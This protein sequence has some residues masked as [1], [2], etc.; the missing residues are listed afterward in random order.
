M[1]IKGLK[2]AFATIGAKQR[3]QYS[4]IAR[5]KNSFVFTAEVDHINKERNIYDHKQGVFHKKVRALSVSDGEAALTV[6]H[7]KELHFA[8]N[9]AFETNL[10]CRLLLV[11]GTKYGTSTGGVKGAVDGDYWIVKQVSGT[12]DEG[13][14]FILERV[15]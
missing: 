8:V 3:D 1:Y 2:A 15:K 9:Q 6:S 5:T 7:A 10:R 14:E 12:V 13:F 11:K 4:W